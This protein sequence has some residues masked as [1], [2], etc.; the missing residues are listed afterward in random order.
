MRLRL[1]AALLLATLGGIAQSAPPTFKLVRIARPAEAEAIPLWPQG[2]LPAAKVPESW[3]RLI[4]DFGDRTV[5]AR[6]ARNISIPTMTPVLPDP[7][8]ATG[9]AVIV[10]PGGAFQSLSMD[11]EGYQVARWLADHG[12]AAFVLKY[13]LNQTPA[14]DDAFMRHVGEVMGAAIASG[15]VAEIKEPRAAVDALQAIKLV[16]AGAGR[17]H[18]DPAHVGII[19]FSAGAM[20]A[21]QSVTAGQGAARPAFFGYIYGPMVAITVPADAPPMFAALALDDMLFGRQGFGI[22]EAW[23]KAARPVELHAY[24]RG[25][26]GFGTGVP[27]TTTTL[28]LDEFRLWLASHRLLA[29]AK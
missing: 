11:S 22:V 2:T 9:A 5:D 3:G 29:A 26:H 23:H 12:I 18:V 21:L 8:K 20:T 15:G 17:W 7:T 10:A 19:G 6:I 25:D 28:M 14:D 4:G 13:R 24:E 16:R 1:A 27:G